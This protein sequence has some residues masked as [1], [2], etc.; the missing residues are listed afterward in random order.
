METYSVYHWIYVEYMYFI[1]VEV[2]IYSICL[3]LFDN[4]ALF[5]SVKDRAC[6]R[7]ELLLYNF[8]ILGSI[9][10]ILFCLL[11]KKLILRSKTIW[12]SMRKFS[13]VVWSMAAYPHM[14]K[15]ETFFLEW[16]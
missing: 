8:K 16:F 5:V 3:F 1:A 6:L 7:I 2:I 11:I 12:K 9:F 4:R 10:D 13:Y 15:E 14:E